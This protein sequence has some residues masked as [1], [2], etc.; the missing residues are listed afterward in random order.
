MRCCVAQVVC[1]G[2]GTIVRA[3]LV[4][5]RERRLTEVIALQL[6]TV[7]V[8]VEVVEERRGSPS[9]AYVDDRGESQDG[10]ENQCNDSNEELEVRQVGLHDDLLI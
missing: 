4:E 8:R 6:I 7:E 9:S 10:N 3:P 5:S 1:V 2:P